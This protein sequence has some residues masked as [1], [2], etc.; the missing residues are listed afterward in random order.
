[1]LRELQQRNNYGERSHPNFS[2]YF[3]DIGNTVTVAFPDILVFMIKHILGLA[4]YKNN[5]I[6]RTG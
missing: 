4:I 3:M 6:P 2:L 1:M 5:L